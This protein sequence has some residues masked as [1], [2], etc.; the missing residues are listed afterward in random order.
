M[1]TLETILTKILPIKNPQG[2]EKRLSDEIL[3]L[4]KTIPFPEISD[5][6]F[7]SKWGLYFKVKSKETKN[8]K[9]GILFLGHMDSDDYSESFTIENG[10]TKATKMIGLDNKAGLSSI[11]YTLHLLK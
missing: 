9:N 3:S 4:I 7:D 1:P 11:L 8:K 5:T 6:E 2:E 10:S